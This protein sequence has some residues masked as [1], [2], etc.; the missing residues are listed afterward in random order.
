MAGGGVE[1]EELRAWGGQLAGLWCLFRDMAVPVTSCA[2]P[3]LHCWAPEGA[4][5]KNHGH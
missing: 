4:S 3:C 1:R 2:V 5:D